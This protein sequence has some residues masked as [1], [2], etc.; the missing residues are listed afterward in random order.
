MPKKILVVDDEPNIVKIVANRL[1]A[2]GYEVVTAYNGLE[3]LEKAGQES[4]D[5]IL[6]DVIMPDMDGYQVLSR[7]K[8]DPRTK[9]IPVI[10]VTARGQLDDVNM[11][12]ELGA[13]DYVVK[14][15]NP[16]LFLQKIHKA[17]EVKS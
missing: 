4:P 11:A 9:P 2:N 6:L 7:L 5:L 13:V 15:F 1:K 3:G 16:V 12:T 17:L 10:M 8:D 14:P